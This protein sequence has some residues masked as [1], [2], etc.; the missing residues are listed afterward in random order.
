M[1]I[2]RCHVR[3]TLLA[4]F[5]ALAFLPRAGWAS[6]GDYLHLASRTSADGASKRGGQRAPAP[7]RGPHCSARLPVPAIPP[8]PKFSP[9]VPRDHLFWVV[10]V[11]ALSPGARDGVDRGIG[12]HS[13]LFAGRLFRPP[14][15]L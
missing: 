2:V 12:S 7:C 15:A 14:R 9:T 3:M 8:A 5:V 4:M 1:R 11:P 13:F 10:H 6:C